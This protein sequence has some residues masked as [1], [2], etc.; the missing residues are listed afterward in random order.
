M[1]EN[2]NKETTGDYAALSLSGNPLDG[3]S[4][5]Q[6]A[7]D[8]LP[9]NQTTVS[10]IEVNDGEQK[11]QAPGSAP[12]TS[13][14]AVEGAIDSIDQ[15]A[16]QPLVTEPS[17][18]ASSQ[19]STEI[20]KPVEITRDSSSPENTTSPEVKTSSKLGIILGVFFLISLLIGASFGYYFIFY[21][22]PEKITGEPK[23]EQTLIKKEPV[24]EKATEDVTASVSESIA[25]DTEI[26]MTVADPVLS[27]MYLDDLNA[28]LE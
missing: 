27:D 8:R 9:P 3:I 5:N 10:E 14:I 7:G 4:H 20:Q 1:E 26:D 16:T 17:T 21:N 13:A 6:E 12:L 22:K 25:L 23:I 24:I 18:T 15:S 19:D 11:S 28:S 2:N